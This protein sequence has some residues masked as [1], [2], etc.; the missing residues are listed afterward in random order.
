MSM[1]FLFCKISHYLDIGDS[2][3]GTTCE[4][5]TWN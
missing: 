3:G 2:G 1:E 4:L 5:H